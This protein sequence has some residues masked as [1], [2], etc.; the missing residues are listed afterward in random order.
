MLDKKPEWSKH[1]EFFFMK[2]GRKNPAPAAYGVRYIP[3]YVIVGKDG[4][5][6]N[7]G[8]CS[9]EEKVINDLIAEEE[10]T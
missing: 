2:D 5:I 1:F 6:R 7:L 8:S 3:Y 9:I 4:R 10:G